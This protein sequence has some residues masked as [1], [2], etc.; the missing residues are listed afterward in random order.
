[1]QSDLTNAC[2]GDAG[3]ESHLDKRA[4]ALPKVGTSASDMLISGHP[5]WGESQAITI[6]KRRWTLQVLGSDGG[7][8]KT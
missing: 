4:V 8:L 7:V 2:P 3:Q 1:M 6:Q 5:G